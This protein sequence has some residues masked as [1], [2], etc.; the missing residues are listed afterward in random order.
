MRCCPAQN[1]RSSAATAGSVSGSG[2]D[3]AVD[4]VDDDHARLAVAAFDPG[5]RA[6][7]APPDRWRQ[8]VDG[9]LGRPHAPPVEVDGAAD[10][11][12]HVAAVR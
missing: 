11:L 2:V 10:D 4:T 5:D 6:A 9:A 3:A 8:H 7:V 1:T 12:G